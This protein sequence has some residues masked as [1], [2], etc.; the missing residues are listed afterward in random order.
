[1]L[2]TH[3]TL[4]ASTNFKSKEN[5]LNSYDAAMGVQFHRFQTCFNA[6]ERSCQI[7]I[8]MAPSLWGYHQHIILS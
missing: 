3:P 7:D 1:M 4:G 8:T 6:P 2:M 5:F